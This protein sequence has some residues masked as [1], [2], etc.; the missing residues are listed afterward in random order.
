MKALTNNR[1][2]LSELNNTSDLSRIARDLN[3]YQSIEKD[4]EWQCVDGT[5]IRSM[6]Y[7]VKHSK[8]FARWSVTM[9]RG[10]VVK[11]GCVHNVDLTRPFYTA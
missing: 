2:L 5:P 3:R 1:A 9:K 11:V 7:L 4:D 8:G 6:S 10:D